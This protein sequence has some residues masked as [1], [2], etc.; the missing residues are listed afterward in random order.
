VVPRIRE[1]P[2]PANSMGRVKFI[3]PNQE[4]IY[5]HDTPGRALFSKTDRHFSNGCIRL[6]DAGRLGQWLLGKPLPARSAK[7]P[8]QP[9]PLPVAVPVYATYLTATESQGRLTFLDDVYDRDGTA[10]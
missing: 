7:K 1:L 9:V 6:E 4:G 5:L 8:E 10:R 2:G 3:F